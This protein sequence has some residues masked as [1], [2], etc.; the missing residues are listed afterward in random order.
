MTRVVSMPKVGAQRS[1]SVPRENDFLRS[2]EPHKL[3]DPTGCSQRQCTRDKIKANDAVKW[4]NCRLKWNFKMRIPCL[5]PW[6]T[7]RY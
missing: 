6:Q 2:S 3:R 7:P 1:L 5:E 4:R